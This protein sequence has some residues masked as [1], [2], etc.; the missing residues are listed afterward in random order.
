[1]IMEDMRRRIERGDITQERAEAIKVNLT[2]SDKT[3]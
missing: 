1:V 2:S 3:N